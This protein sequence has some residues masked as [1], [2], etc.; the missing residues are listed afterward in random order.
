MSWDPVT[1]TIM[2]GKIPW[3]MTGGARGGT[4][5][6]EACFLWRGNLDPR[7]LNKGNKMALAGGKWAFISGL[8]SLGL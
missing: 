7:V 2:K 1:G 4:W 6:R 3:K 5:H 8:C